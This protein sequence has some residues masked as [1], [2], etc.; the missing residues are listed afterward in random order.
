MK[1]KNNFSGNG[2]VILLSLV[3]TSG[4]AI[5]VVIKHGYF[6]PRTQVIN[7]IVAAPLLNTPFNLNA[8]ALFE[9]NSAVLKP[10]GKRSIDDLAFRIKSNNITVD[11]FGIKGYTDRIGKDASNQALSQRRADSIVSQLKSQGIQSIYNAQGMGESNPITTNCSDKMKKA[12]LI[13]CLAPDRRV[14][15]TI[16]SKK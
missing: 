1:N 14:E 6:I 9:F 4:L 10:G 5:A 8:D 7:K 2:L 16:N 13:K 3:L 11:S 15:I 12:T